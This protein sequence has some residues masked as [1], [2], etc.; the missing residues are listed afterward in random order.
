MFLM[1]SAKVGDG[2]GTF[3]YASVMYIGHSSTFGTFGTLR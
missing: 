3:T 1:F 2:G